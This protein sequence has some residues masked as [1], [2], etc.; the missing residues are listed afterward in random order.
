MIQHRQG[1]GGITGLNQQGR[2]V[3]EVR[4]VVRLLC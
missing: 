3:V 2:L 1:G 4:Y